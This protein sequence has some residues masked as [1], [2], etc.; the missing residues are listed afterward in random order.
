[1]K[2]LQKTQY[3]ETQ[4]KNWSSSGHLLTLGHLLFLIYIHDIHNL[5]I[6]GRFFLLMIT[7][8][9]HQYPSIA[10]MKKHLERDI[11]IMMEYFRVN[12][13]KLNVSNTKL[14][15]FCSSTPFV[16]H[17]YFIRRWSN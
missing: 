16:D 5:P 8:Y 14:L 17:N 11:D 6:L 4:L 7:V 3:I 12:K 9:L 10:E 1:M 2:V 15:N 13:L